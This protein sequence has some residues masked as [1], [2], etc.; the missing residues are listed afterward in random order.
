[1]NRCKSPL[2]VLALGAAFLSTAPVP[3][4]AQTPHGRPVLPAPVC[5]LPAA[6]TP[7]GRVRIDGWFGPSV[8]DSLVILVDDTVQWRGVYRLCSEASVSPNVPWLPASSDSI[9]NVSVIKGDTVRA[10]Y[11]LGGH[12]PSA[13]I[14]GTR[15]G[16]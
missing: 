8:N 6:V 7:P 5:A 4:R 13:L 9:R 10:L 11:H 1:M 3:T 14:I 12:H 16:P 2:K 15:R